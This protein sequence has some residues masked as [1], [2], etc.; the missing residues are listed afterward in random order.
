MAGGAIPPL[1]NSYSH[2]R[3]RSGKT[4]GIGAAEVDRGFGSADDFAGGAVRSAQAGAGRRS[5]RFRGADVR[6]SSGGS[7]VGETG[8]TA[9][10]NG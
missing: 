5:W 8:V 7:V 4:M 3:R 2:S 1:L 6:V 10:L 9:S